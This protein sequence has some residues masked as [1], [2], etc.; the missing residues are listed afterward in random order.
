[1][2]QF[3][4]APLKVLQHT[5]ISFTEYHSKKKNF[6]EGVYAEENKALSKHGPF[7]AHT[8]ESL[9]E[10]LNIRKRWKVCVQKLLASSASG[11]LPIQSHRSIK[12]ECEKNQKN[13]LN[14]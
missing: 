4:C 7:S 1:M 8:H 5:K 2:D 10:V 9:L 14:P 11:K 6:V 3:R 13:F 12:N